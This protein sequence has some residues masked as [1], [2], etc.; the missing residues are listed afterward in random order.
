MPKGYAMRA[1]LTRL[2]RSALL[3]LRA[4]L[5]TGYNAVI[6]VTDPDGNWGVASSG[7]ENYIE[8]VLRAATTAAAIAD[9]KS[10]RG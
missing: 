4:Q 6:V 1:E 8:R 7:D 3:L 9:G 5:P 2:G 10:K